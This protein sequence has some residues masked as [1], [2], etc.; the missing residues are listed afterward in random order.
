MSGV[1]LRRLFVTVAAIF[2]AG[3]AFAQKLS[4]SNHRE[5]KIP[6]YALLRIGPFY[7]NLTFNQVAGYRY[8][9]SE[10]TGTD[11]L[12]ANRRGAIKEDGSEFPLKTSLS[13]RNYLLVTRNIDLDFSGRI[14][15]EHYPLDTQ[16]DDFYLDMVDEGI[17]GNLS[18][19]IEITPFVKM[20][21][22]ENAA[23]RTDYVDTR[24]VIDEQ[25]GQRYE[26]FQNDA[27]FMLDWLMAPE[28]NLHLDVGRKDVV[29]MEEGSFDDQECV[30]WSENIG[31]EQQFNVF[32]S[33]G[34]RGGLNQAE[35]ES[36]NRAD[37]SSYSVSCFADAMLTKRTTGNASLG[38]SGGSVGSGS[39]RYGESN[40]N[41]GTVIGGLTLNT[42]LNRRAAHQYG[43]I[44][45]QRGGFN[46][47]FEVWNEA[48]YRFTWSGDFTTFKL[49]SRHSLVETSSDITGDYLDW[50]NGIEISRELLAWLTLDFDAWYTIRENKTVASSDA[51]GLDTDIEWRNDYDTWMGRLGTTFNLTEKLDFRTY[52]QYVERLSESEDLEY[53]RDIFVAQF[54]FTHKF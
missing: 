42:R 17:Y 24:G 8:T 32:M 18:T 16:E 12:F 35:Y 52:Y 36:T 23:Y 31:Y 10:G 22:Y 27:G 54:S 11:F 6:E 30:T 25:G 28:K 41:P 34:L 21:V 2:L 1:E 51:T 13:F 7:S 20:M 4:F 45:S 14:V 39:P 38:Y 53:N 48:L 44:R 19:E 40:E 26:N 5:I 29:P 43:Y 49:S 9:R 46:A 47:A 3:G 15:G 37:S 33:G 50:R